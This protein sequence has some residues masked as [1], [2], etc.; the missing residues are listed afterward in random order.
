MYN[1]DSAAGFTA[2]STTLWQEVPKLKFTIKGVLYTSKSTSSNGTVCT[3]GELGFVV[4]GKL[5]AP[6][7]HVN[8]PTKVTACLG[9]DT[10]T[11]PGTGSFTAD[12]GQPGVT[13]QT[14]QLAADSKVKIS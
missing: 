7:A 8:E 10:Y 11:G 12:L 6:A 5:T 3:G 14:A 1:Y 2:L 9:T 4:K 13:I